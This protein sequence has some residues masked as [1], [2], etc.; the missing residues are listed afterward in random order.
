MSTFTIYYGSV[1]PLRAVGRHQCR[2]LAF[3][4]K[5]PGWHTFAQDKTTKRAVEGLVRRRCIEVSGDQFRII[6]P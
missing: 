5:Y 3:A 2:L 4:E 1:N 6:Y